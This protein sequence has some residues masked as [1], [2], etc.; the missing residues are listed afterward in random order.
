ME[1][2]ILVEPKPAF[3]EQIAAYRQEFL[4]E[5]GSM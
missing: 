4:D 3:S 2:L 1:H 5:G